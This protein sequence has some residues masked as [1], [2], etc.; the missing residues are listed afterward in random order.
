MEAMEEQISYKHVAN[1]D[2]EPE[3]S[4]TN[5]LKQNIY[6]MTNKF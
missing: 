1:P 6:S 2:A 4:R 5:E 3:K